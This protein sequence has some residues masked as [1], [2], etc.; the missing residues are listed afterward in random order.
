MNRRVLFS[1]PER[2]AETP[3]FVAALVDP[4]APPPEPLRRPEDLL[5]PG[6]PLFV[7]TGPGGLEPDPDGHPRFRHRRARA[8]RQPPSAQGALEA[9]DLLIYVFTNSNYNNRDNTDFIGRMLTGIGRRP[10]F[11]VY[12]C[13]PSFTAEEV[14]DH[15]MT[16]ARNIY[17]ADADRHVL[18]IFRADEDNRVAAGERPVVLRPVAAGPRPSTRRCARSTS[19]A[20]AVS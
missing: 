9:A 4:S 6:G 20:C 11:L 7:R 2:A 3:A 18:G 13:Y 1:I 8:V 10:C 12:R 17:G 5:Q 15:A 16:V 19:A 14:R